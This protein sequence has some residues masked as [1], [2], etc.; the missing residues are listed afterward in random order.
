MTIGFSWISLNFSCSSHSTALPSVRISLRV[1]VRLVLT[2][3][4]RKSVAGMKL[5]RDQIEVLGLQTNVTF[6]KVKVKVR[7]W[8]FGGQLEH[9]WS[10]S[11]EFIVFYTVDVRK[12]CDWREGVEIDCAVENLHGERFETLALRSRPLMTKGF[13]WISLNFSCSSHSTALPL[14]QISLRVI[15][16]LVLTVFTVNSGAGMKLHGD[17]IE[18]LGLQTN[19]TFLKVKVK[20]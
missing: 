11:L 4:T 1:F 15:V 20:T 12:E 2:I 3:Y 18:I 13:S 19:V 10:S 7:V 14:V 17:H 8:N 6:L 5:H 9:R 16:R